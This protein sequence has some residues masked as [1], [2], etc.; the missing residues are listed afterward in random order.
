GAWLNWAILFVVMVGGAGVR[1]FMNVRYAGQRWLAPAITIGVITLA[2]VMVGTRVRKAPPEVKGAVDF[3]RAEE[4]ITKRC[5]PCHS[6]HATHTM[7]ATPPN[8][9]MFDTPARIEAMVPRI[10]ERA[11][12]NQ[13]MPFLNRTEITDEE[14]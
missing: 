13:T 12:V 5:V 6:P 11:V 10:K 4:I 8:N 7:F 1:H 2:G 3:A 9:V 14:R